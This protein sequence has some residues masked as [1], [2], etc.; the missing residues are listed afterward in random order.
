[1]KLSGLG[2][3]QCPVQL[4]PVPVQTT[5]L[6]SVFGSVISIG[7][8]RSAP[9]IMIFEVSA[10]A[11]NSAGIASRRRMTITESSRFTVH[12]TY[13]SKLDHRRLGR[14]INAPVRIVRGQPGTKAVTAR[15]AIDGPRLI[16]F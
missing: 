9:L 5:K 1:M 13:C 7:A 14:S 3:E 16:G 8:L 2:G 4:V 6:A 10:F 15:S 12:P 11:N